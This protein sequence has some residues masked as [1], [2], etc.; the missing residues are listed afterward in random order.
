[1]GS[2]CVNGKVGDVE[3]LGMKLEGEGALRG[4]LGR[5]PSQFTA[6][7]FRQIWRSRCQPDDSPDAGLP[8][9]SKAIT[10]LQDVFPDVPWVKQIVMGM[11][12]ADA[13]MIKFE[14]FENIGIRVGFSDRV[15]HQMKSSSSSSSSSG[16]ANWKRKWSLQEVKQL[17]KDVGLL[18]AVENEPEMEKK[19]KEGMMQ[20]N[21]AIPAELVCG[22]LAQWLQEQNVASHP[23]KYLNI[24]IV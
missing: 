19:I 10:A 8:T 23:F 4:K 13:R 14:E 20:S 15:C 5:S 18:E 16:G 1:M 24:A 21:E 17:A 12:A 11:R 9:A 22:K 7:Q 2:V 6:Q 3:T